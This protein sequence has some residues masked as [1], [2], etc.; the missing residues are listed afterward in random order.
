[1]LAGLRDTYADLD[2]VLVV[3]ALGPRGDG[4]VAEERAD[5]AE[6]AAYHSGQVR[7][8]RTAGIPVAISF[9]VETDGRLPDGTTLAD[10]IR[11]VDEQAAPDWFG[12]N[13]A[14]PT[15]VAPGLDGGEWQQRIGLFRPNS[16]TLTHAELDAMEVLDEGDL[17]L[18]TGSFEQLR[19]ELPGLSVLGGCCGTDTRHVA[20]LWGL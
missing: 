7:A 11:T 6:A 19:A 14:H 3:G 15:H 20:A 13:C 5:P 4:Y 12:V 18:L 2:E 17:S 16:S 9:T 10:A 8:A 1:M